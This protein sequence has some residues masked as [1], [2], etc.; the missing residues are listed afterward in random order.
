[1]SSESSM[2]LMKAENRK[3]ENRKLL[4]CGLNLTLFSV[5]L[6]YSPTGGRYYSLQQWQ[7]V[8]GSNNHIRRELLQ[9][10]EEEIEI[11]MI[12]IILMALTTGSSLCQ[13]L[14]SLAHLN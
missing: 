10:R 5:G 8:G 11:I 9:K 6:Y 2:C 1:M 7:G 12:T 14:F 13:P 3:I 4:I